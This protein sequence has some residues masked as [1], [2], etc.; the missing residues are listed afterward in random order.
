MRVRITGIKNALNSAR[1]FII[2]HS[3]RVDSIYLKFMLKACT[4]VCQAEVLYFGY[5]FSQRGCVTARMWRSERSAGR[6]QLGSQ[7]SLT[8]CFC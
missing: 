5:D 8:P 4:I 3:V 1:F 7:E 2:F 6:F